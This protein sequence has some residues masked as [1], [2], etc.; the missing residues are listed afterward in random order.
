MGRV[1]G[2]SERRRSEREDAPWSVN[3]VGGRPLTMGERLRLALGV[4]VAT[5]AVGALLPLLAA[6][7]VLRRRR[8][9]L[10]VLLVLLALGIGRGLQGEADGPQPEQ[11]AGARLTAARTAGEVNG[12]VADRDGTPLAGARVRLLRGERSPTEVTTD[13]EGR[14]T[15]SVTPGPVTIE[16]QRRGE[17]LPAMRTGLLV[18]PDGAGVGLRLTDPGSLD[19]LVEDEHGLP[20]ARCDV[21]VV[22]PLVTRFGN[23]SESAM[24]PRAWTGDD[25]VARFTGVPAGRY[26]VR[27]RAPGATAPLLGT[28][29]VR[30]REAAHV[31]LD[32]LARRT[33]RVT[34][35]DRAGAPV[36]GVFMDVS[37]PG[38]NWRGMPGA[39]T[40]R[41]GVAT[42]PDLPVGLAEVHLGKGGL[43]RM[44]RTS[45]DEATFTWTRETAIEVR[46]AVAGHE[47]DVLVATV[48]PDVVHMSHARVID[49]RL[50][51]TITPP[52]GAARVFLVAPDRRL[53]P[54]ELGT[55]GDGVDRLE[56]DARFV[57]GARVTG[58]LAVDRNGVGVPGRVR[59]DGPL[60][61]ALEAQEQWL[62]GTDHDEWITV[63]EWTRATTAGGDFELTG[64]PPGEATVHLEGVGASPRTIVVRAHVGRDPTNVGDVT[65]SDER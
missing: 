13:A 28:V 36:E 7:E 27:V 10:L 17:P 1:V 62:G 2:R 38:I 29:E 65:V 21:Q 47:G 63:N 25:G 41:D 44:V 45:A 61:G 3:L 31:V 16:V 60:A 15:A 64:L 33:L 49:G 35:V 55:V 54:V 22:D 46:G 56:F 59:V 11:P 58:R 5:I 20:L 24:Q 6:H 52:A 42:L 14:W 23:Y 48:L 32:A 43:W 50:D 18:H 12:V 26:F 53:A 57:E 30:P 9:R 40:D 4:V 39:T 8:G 34:V 51:T 19:V 37:M